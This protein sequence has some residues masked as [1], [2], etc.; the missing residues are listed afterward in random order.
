MALMVIPS[1]DEA[2]ERV[3][4]LRREIARHDRL[5][6][7]LDAPEISDAEYDA[8]MRELEALEKAYPELVT[9]DSPTQRVGGQ[10]L[11]AFETV[12]HRVPMLSLTNAF[13]DDDLRAFDERVRR[14][15]G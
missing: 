13:S 6:Y 12:V 10:P 15:L 2:R 8:L 9:P 3:E 11:A 14:L 7:E 5:Y 1:V 4:L